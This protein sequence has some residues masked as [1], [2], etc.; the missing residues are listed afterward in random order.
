MKVYDVINYQVVHSVSY[1]SPILCMA[2]APDSS[3]FVV[4][5]ETGLVTIHRKKEPKVAEEKV[6]TNVRQAVFVP[7]ADDIVLDT[8]HFANSSKLQNQ[9]KRFEFTAA[10]QTSFNQAT[11]FKKPELFIATCD[12]VA[13]RRML[14]NALAKLSEKYQNAI[15]DFI[16]KYVTLPRYEGVS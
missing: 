14:D 13:R 1:P 9:L 5:S 4:G 15:L 11:R 2:M 3:V 16:C 8:V 7:D 10:L 6:E 12:E